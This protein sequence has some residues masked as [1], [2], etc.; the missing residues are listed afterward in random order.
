MATRIFLAKGYRRTRMDDVTRS[1]GL[2]PAAIYRYVESKEALFD[3]ILR[4]STEPG[5][6]A[7]PIPVP[8]PKPGA[9]LAF[10]RKT[11]DR[12]GRLLHLEAALRGRAPK[13]IEPELEGIVRELYAKTARYRTS[14]ALLDAAALDWPELARLWSGRWRATVVRKLARYL[15]VR[16]ARK[17]LRPVPDPR[18][19]A[20]LIIEM[21]AFMAMHRHSDLSP[22][23]ID[24]KVAEETVVSAVVQALVPWGG[25]PPRRGGR[26]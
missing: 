2:S 3:L 16:I 17:L 20:R 7:F 19:W 5:R 4:F 14:I 25:G 13:S 22:T 12:E 26:G 18:A 24:E 15:E 23:P 6:D 10:V 21:V 1:M 9:S 11:L 8:T